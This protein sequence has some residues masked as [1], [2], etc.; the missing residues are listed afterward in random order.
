MTT[1]TCPRCTRKIIIE[2]PLTY[3]T[4]QCG[5]CH[6]EVIC[7]LTTSEQ[8]KLDKDYDLQ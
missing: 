4:V 1:P 7:D 2:A 6:E 8:F 3:G 5:G